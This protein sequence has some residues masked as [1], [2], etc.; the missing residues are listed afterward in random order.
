MS[1]KEI[2]DSVIIEAELIQETPNAFELDCE[3][4][5]NWFPKSQVNFDQEKNELELPKW[6]AIQKFPNEF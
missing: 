3:G 4:D 5:V 1:K 6:M 2:K